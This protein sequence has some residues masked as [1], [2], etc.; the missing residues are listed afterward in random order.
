M[1][2]C[3]SRGLTLTDFSKMSSL[4][5]LGRLTLCFLFISLEPIPFEVI[6]LITQQINKLC[7]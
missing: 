4:S 5:F 1:Q 6:L 3:F 2:K 7:P